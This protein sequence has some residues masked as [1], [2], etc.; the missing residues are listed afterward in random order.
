MLPLVADTSMHFADYALL[1]V[2]SLNISWA[3]VL[4]FL[5][6]GMLVTLSPSR[7]TSEIKRPKDD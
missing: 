4:F 6:L 3:I 2:P 5:I 7:R 1:A